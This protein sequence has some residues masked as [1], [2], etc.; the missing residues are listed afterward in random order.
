MKSQ[1]RGN[2]GRSIRERVKD[3]E[4]EE[5]TV[6]ERDWLMCGSIVRK[7]KFGEGALTKLCRIES[8]L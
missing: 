2:L 8:R 4:K 1:A 7:R 3:L 5:L 6:E